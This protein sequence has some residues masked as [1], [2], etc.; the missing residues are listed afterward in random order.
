MLPQFPNTIYLP[1]YVYYEAYKKL[2]CIRYAFAITLLLV[3]IK[4]LLSATG[5]YIFLTNYARCSLGDY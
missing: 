1:K 4:L 5:F 2:Y 3:L